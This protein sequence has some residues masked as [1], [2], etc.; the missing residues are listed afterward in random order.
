[1]HKAPP[2]KISL[3]LGADNEKKPLNNS[4]EIPNAALM[5]E[6]RIFRVK[7]NGVHSLN[8]SRKP[9]RPVRITQSVDISTAVSGTI[10]DVAVTESM[11]MTMVRAHGSA[12]F[13]ML[14]NKL[15]SMRLLL[16]S[17]ASTNDGMP[18]VNMLMSVIW[19]GMNGYGVWKNRNKIASSVE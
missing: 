19:M 6:K 1:M 8:S 17:S 7:L 15:P 13:I 12:F 14:K 16:G 9:F 4:M 5:T 3:K 2:T 18:M 10:F 11:E